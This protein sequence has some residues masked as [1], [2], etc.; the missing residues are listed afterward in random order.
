MTRRQKYLHAFSRALWDTDFLS[1]RITLA[2]GEFFWAIMLLW[3]GD[4]FD[5]Q[6][7]S[8][9]A[10]VM[11]ENAWGLLFLASGVTQLSIVLIEDMHSRFARYF[12]AWNAALWCYTVYAMIASVYPP[13]AAIGGEIALAITA[14]WIFTR[15]YILAKGYCTAYGYQ[16]THQ[17]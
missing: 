15:P 2:I 3:P 12:A 10:A 9:M 16:Q 7:Y 14:T 6:T 17:D 1:S 4:T 8:H 13:P 5:R 11:P